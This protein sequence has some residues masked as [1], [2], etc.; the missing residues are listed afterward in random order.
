MNGK[1]SEEYQNQPLSHP[2]PRT[3]TSDPRRSTSSVRLDAPRSPPLPAEALLGGVEGV[4]SPMVPCALK[5]GKMAG[6]RKNHP[7]ATYLKGE[8]YLKFPICSRSVIAATKQIHGRT[9]MLNAIASGSR[10]L[11]TKTRRTASLSHIRQPVARRELS[12]VP[13]TIAVR[14]SPPRPVPQRHARFTSRRHFVSSSTK[15]VSTD[16]TVSENQQYDVVIIGGGNAGLALAC[17]LGERTD[18]T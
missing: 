10:A 4:L 8:D 11:R 9:M 13:C 2:M 18:P 14:P 5:I 12:T 16:P 1:E 7:T 17:A 3:N 6:L 15:T